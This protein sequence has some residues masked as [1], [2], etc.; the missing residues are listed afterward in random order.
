MPAERTNCPPPP[1]CNSI[2]C[3]SV[4]NVIFFSGK[5]FPAVI[6][7]SGDVITVS[8]MFKPIGCKI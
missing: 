1:G 7:A 5:Q 3:T 2:L 8:P 6:F 4:P